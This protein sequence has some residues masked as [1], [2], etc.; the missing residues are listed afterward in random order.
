M[1]RAQQPNVNV[2][3]PTGGT[4]PTAPGV[5]SLSFKRKEEAEA[6][7]R[8]QELAAQM[9][10][11]EQR[12][13][14]EK[15]QAQAEREMRRRE[16]EWSS[17]LQGYQMK[18]EEINMGLRESTGLERARLLR[19]LREAKR[20]MVEK[21]IEG[22]MGAED[23]RE[24]Q[25][26]N[27]SLMF[28]I[29]QGVQRSADHVNTLKSVGDTAGVGSMGIAMSDV[30]E[31]IDDAIASIVGGVPLGQARPETW[32]E[33]LGAVG[34]GEIGPPSTLPGG[35]G[36]LGGITMAGG[37]AVPTVAVQ[38][39][40]ML[41][42][43][44]WDW[45]DAAMGVGESTT[46]TDTERA[47]MRAQTADLMKEHKVVE[48][49]LD[50]ALVPALAK[51]AASQMATKLK[52]DQ[53]DV[54]NRVASA[55]KVLATN[56]NAQWEDLK[57]VL[58]GAA[59]TKGEEELRGQKGAEK[60]AIPGL[61]TMF[62]G[63]LEGLGRT[64]NNAEIQAD[65]TYLQLDENGMPTGLTR[66]DA[67]DVMQTEAR[68][69]LFGEL[70][71]V[72]NRGMAAMDGKV[73]TGAEASVVADA[74]TKAWLDK[75]SP[76]QAR[77]GLAKAV[78]NDPSGRMASDF[79]DLA[80]RAYSD[81]DPEGYF[82]ALKLAKDTYAQIVAE[83]DKLAAESDVLLSMSESPTPTPQAIAGARRKME[84]ART[85]VEE[86]LGRRGF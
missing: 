1:S 81:V 7:S 17:L 23:L 3:D 14:A 32:R 26:K 15:A 54:E 44:L 29:I 71:K 74:M 77:V 8:R 69:L 11:A 70:E 66:M 6:Q 10:I 84:E 41:A 85:G 53:E 28:S 20:K 49:L 21:G 58:G 86:F 27:E 42:A 36:E 34:R 65:Q 78:M 12:L 25:E 55:L 56:P 39:A 75:A 33:S 80:L 40:A 79:V 24:L 5:Q 73:T 45:W 51:E 83:H 67:Q 64:A 52:A 46:Y 38:G 31:G 62:F 2:F 63:F 82:G 16:M 35:T 68:I 72:A 13:T 43:Q 50:G 59:L 30:Q 37:T 61:A 47:G 9:E 22:K 19:E 57:G 4:S 48:H 76:E 18:V 60:E